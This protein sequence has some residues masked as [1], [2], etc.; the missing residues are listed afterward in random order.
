MQVVLVGNIAATGQLTESRLSK[1]YKHIKKQMETKHEGQVKDNYEKDDSTIAVKPTKKI[2]IVSSVDNKTII[3]T[4]ETEEDKQ[5]FIKRSR[6]KKKRL[7]SKAVKEG[8]IISVYPV[9]V[10]LLFVPLFAT[11][12]PILH[13]QLS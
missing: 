5:E 4:I 13:F 7:R 3:E 11:L 2:F 1:L 6:I 9:P 8:K 10:C 12:G